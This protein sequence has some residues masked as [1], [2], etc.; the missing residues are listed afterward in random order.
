MRPTAKILTLLLFAASIQDLF[1]QTYDELYWAAFFKDAINWPSF[2][3]KKKEMVE[4]IAIGGV[5]NTDYDSTYDHPYNI[6]IA[7]EVTGAS[8]SSAVCDGNSFTYGGTGGADAFVASYSSTGAL[9]WSRYLGNFKTVEY[10]HC[11]TVDKVLV[12]PGPTWHDYIYIAGEVKNNGAAS[13]PPSFVCSNNGCAPFTTTDDDNS[14][15]VGNVAFVAK[16]DGANGQLISWRYIGGNPMSPNIGRDDQVL[17]LAVNPIN[18]HL[19]VT[20]Y[21]TTDGLGVNATYPGWDMQLDEGNTLETDGGDGFIAE[22]DECLQTMIFFTYVGG[23]GQDRLHDVK[24]DESGNLFLSGTAASDGLSY[25]KPGYITYQTS[26]KLLLD[27]MLMKLSPLPGGGYERLFV[28]YLGGGNNDRG[29]RIAIDKSG[30][31]FMTGYTFSNN[32]PTLY[33]HQASQCGLPGTYDA[34]VSKFDSS[35][36]L[37]W[38][39]YLGGTL[40]DKANDIVISPIDK[41][42]FVTGQ[43]NSTNLWKTISSTYVSSIQDTVNGDGTTVSNDGFIVGLND[44]TGAG[45]G[46]VVFATYLGGSSSEDDAGIKSYT[47]SLAMGGN[48]ELLFAENTKSKNI[49][50]VTN[51]TN[52]IGAFSGNYDIYLGL[53]RYHPNPYGWPRLV[54]VHQ[55][56]T[57]NSVSIYPNPASGA[58]HL[59]IFSE[60]SCPASIFA[61]DLL[62]RKTNL[63]WHNLTEGAND[64]EID[65]SDFEKGLYQI[66]IMLPNGIKRKMLLIEK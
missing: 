25:A 62:G 34:F 24:F 8:G 23:T 32:F 11:L 29:R 1:A 49:A 35:G 37:K 20:G 66:E 38:S 5:N 48:G 54:P 18:R 43:S 7:G 27:A 61:I 42:I 39:T 22:F 21:T 30:N 57:D 53:I 19:I 26:K 40:N 46:T 14:A 28:T 9:N 31:C 52:V 44:V 55:T 16:Y 13:V 12:G 51:P 41:A 3:W 2:H 47:P 58:T 10:A 59:L 17:G 63:P 33:P 50:T 45:Q 64:I 36:N 60:I 56:T 15:F 6:Y 4:G 65:L